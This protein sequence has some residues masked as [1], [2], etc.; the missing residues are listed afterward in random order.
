MALFKYTHTLTFNKRGLFYGK[1][2][3]T[4]GS[5][6]FSSHAVLRRSIERQK[7]S[8]FLAAQTEEE[9]EEEGGNRALKIFIRRGKRSVAET[10]MFFPQESVRN[11]LGHIFEAPLAVLASFF[12]FC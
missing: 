6:T 4:S 8:L 9:G 11:F 2:R 1:R 3:E 7:L 5:E 10:T 12:A